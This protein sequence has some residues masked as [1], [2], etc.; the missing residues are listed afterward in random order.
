MQNSQP[1]EKQEYYEGIGRTYFTKRSDIK[2]ISI[3]IIPF[4][5]V[6][7]NIPKRNSFE[8]GEKFLF[9]KMEWIQKSIPKIKEIERS[10]T[11]FDED[12]V[13]STHFHKLK[14]IH[15]ERSNITLKITDHFVILRCPKDINVK[16]RRIQSFIRS[17]IE[18]TFRR[19]AKEYLPSRLAKFA[20]KHKLTYNVVRIK[21]NITRWGS[22]SSNQNINLNLYLMQLPLDLVDHIILHEMVHLVHRNHGKGFWKMFENISPGALEKSKEMKKYRIAI[23]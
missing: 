18:E 17:G 11:V 1:V 8:D 2:R 19:E 13:F 6:I 4:K 15:E 3:S 21:N 23:Y 12:T 14:I 16:H 9:Q 5:R 22:C 20:K 7:V 10:V